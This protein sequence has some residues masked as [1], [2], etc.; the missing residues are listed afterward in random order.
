M[1]N[2]TQLTNSHDNQQFSE[3]KDCT[4]AQDYCEI[5][6]GE[7]YKSTTVDGLISGLAQPTSN[8]YC[9][10]PQPQEGEY[11]ITTVIKPEQFVY[12]VPYYL[13][14]QCIQSH[15]QYLFIINHVA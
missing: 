13:H 14:K 3:E 8:Y 10:T 9:A 1:T 4:Q 5:E 7:K 12:L 15:F 11:E 2:S 6:D